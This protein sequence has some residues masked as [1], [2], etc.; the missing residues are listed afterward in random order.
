MK[1][2]PVGAGRIDRQVKMTKLIVAFRNFA[3]APQNAHL[4][5]PLVALF[6]LGVW[7]LVWDSRLQTCIHTS[8]E[9]CVMGAKIY[10]PSYKP[11]LVGYV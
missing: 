2:R 7:A 9:T 8:R 6:I 10:K 3:N 1:I 5:F 4:A 11:K